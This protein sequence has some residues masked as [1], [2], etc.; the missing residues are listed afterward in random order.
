MI[1]IHVLLWLISPHVLRM[2]HI[3]TAVRPHAT[4]REF[5]IELDPETLTKAQE[6]QKD[7]FKFVE[8]NPEAPENIPD[9]TNN[10][11][12]Q[13]QQAAQEKPT[14]DGKSDRPATEGKKDFESN[15]IVSGRLI[16]PMERVEAAPPPVEAPPVETPP[17]TAPRAEQTPPS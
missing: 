10:F 2:D 16:Q 15:Q 13:N 14:P 12:A 9:K 17:V 6:K 5:N 3:P 11:A 4:S 7:P 8:T 1:L